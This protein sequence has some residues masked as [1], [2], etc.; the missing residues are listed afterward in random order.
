MITRIH[1]YTV[2]TIS[3]SAVAVI[4]VTHEQ[5]SA[6]IF[7]RKHFNEFF[8]NHTAISQ[9]GCVHGRSASHALLKVMHELFVAA[10]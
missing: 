10:D 1:Y 8:D 3:A 6:E 4:G 5:E 7:V 9:F 2:G